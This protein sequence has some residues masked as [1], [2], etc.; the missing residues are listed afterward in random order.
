MEAPSPL[1]PQPLMRK[2]NDPMGLTLI[3]ET[4][5]LSHVALSGRLDALSVEALEA[6]TL[7]AND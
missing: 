6:M 7:L 2:G 5:T 1:W 3:Q 4:E